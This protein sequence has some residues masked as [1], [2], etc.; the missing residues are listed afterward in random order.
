VIASLARLFA[1]PPSRVETQSHDI[2]TR[3]PD[4]AMLWSVLVVDA[5]SRRRPPIIWP[6]A[7]LGEAILPGRLVGCA[8][9]MVRHGPDDLLAAG[10]P[11][12]MRRWANPVPAI[13]AAIRAGCD[14][15]VQDIGPL[16]TATLALGHPFDL[17]STGGHIG[18]PRSLVAGAP[19][20]AELRERTRTLLV[21]T[22]ESELRAQ[23]ARFE[24]TRDLMPDIALRFTWC[25]RPWG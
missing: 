7:A 25:S 22:L 17:A 23:L 8:A 10:P 9:V 3:A 12:G 1:P 6:I 18:V 19:S 2:P 11:H 14:A 24:A 13:E 5:Q 20:F 21:Q 15:P 16:A 4:G